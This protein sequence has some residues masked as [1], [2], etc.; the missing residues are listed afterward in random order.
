MTMS[1]VE[2]S[3]LTEGPIKSCARVEV[4][5]FE[6]GE[7]GPRWSRRWMVVGSDRKFMLSDKYPKMV[8]IE[9]RVSET[10]NVMVLKGRGYGWQID[11]PINDEGSRR[12]VVMFTDSMR[13]EAVDD[14]FEAAQWLSGY[15]NVDGC[16]LV[17]MPADY[18]RKDS[19]GLARFGFADSWSMSLGSDAS[20]DELNKKILENGRNSVPKER[21]GHDMWIAGID[22]FAE[23]AWGKIKINGQVVAVVKP[24]ERCSRTLVRR[25]AETVDELLNKDKEPLATLA[26]FRKEV[27]SGKTIF[28]QKLAPKW[29]GVPQ[30]IHVGDEVEVLV[31]KSSPNLIE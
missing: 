28:G 22:P 31:Y 21:F 6:V 29:T 24:I 26:T 8:F 15:L 12:I 20:L 18:V 7:M 27:Q 2:I 23:D 16:R 13:Y 1:R 14:G 30:E 19:L 11:V 17:H 5:K 9:P 3:S 10:D 25:E 4:E